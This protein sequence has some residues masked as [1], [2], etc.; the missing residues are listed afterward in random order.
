M[1][2]QGIHRRPLLAAAGLGLFAAALS[3]FL[4]WRVFEGIPHVADGV[5]YAFQARLF[6]AGHVFLPPPAVPE[7]FAADNVILNATRW[8]GKYPPGFPFVL[9]LGYL[10]GLPWLVNPFLTGLAVLGAFRF[11]RTL[12]DEAI[13]LLAAAL[14]A[15][16]PF[17][18]LMGASFMAHP[19]TLAA[20]LWSLSFLAEGRENGRARDF[21]LAGLLGGVAFLARPVSAFALLFPAV[22]WALWPRRQIRGGL[23]TFAALALG[24]LPF[25]LAFLAWNAAVS[26]SPFTTSYAVYDPTEGFAGIGG[27]RIPFLQR[28]AAHVP[29]YVVDLARSSWRWPWPDLLPLLALPWATGERRRDGVLL[30]CVATLVLVHSAYYYYGTN[31]SGPRFGFEALGPFSLLVARGLLTIGKGTI[32]LFGGGRAV[33]VFSFAALAGILGLPLSRLPELSSYFSGAYHG[34][35][36]VPLA[37]AAK[38]GV[39]ADAL[40]LVS[41]NI[42][43]ALYGSFLLHNGVPPAAGRRVYAQ[44]LPEKRGDLETA[45]PRAETWGVRVDLA[46]AP[47]PDP[48]IE[49]TWE[50]REV[51]WTRLR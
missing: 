4:C 6:A 1:R 27:E 45:Y 30:A 48:L 20:S 12:H 41:G 10:A 17:A 22:V 37:T 51:R 40:V 50:I 34:H 46:Q 42:R 15:V 13:G 23:S 33:R 38:A 35:S 47:R 14:L 24:F 2:A 36:A 16:S 3:S 29:M 18:L 49:E 32:R 31:H 39:G 26:G 8:C 19:L 11:G 21:V 9:S 28:L 44:D 25:F 7:A 5:S 43:Q